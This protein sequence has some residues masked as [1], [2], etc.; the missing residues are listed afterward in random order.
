MFKC[1]KPTVTALT[2]QLVYSFSSK[3]VTIIY[4]FGH[5]TTVL[6]IWFKFI[7]I[8]NTQIF[9]VIL[10]KMLMVHYLWQR[11]VKTVRAN[12]PIQTVRE[13]GYTESKPEIKCQK[14]LNFPHP[15]IYLSNLT[16][17]VVSASGNLNSYME[18]FKTSSCS[19]IYE[20]PHQPMSSENI[21]VGFL[22]Y[23]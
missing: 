9:G 4:L 3:R 5:F 13:D 20:N 22:L 21:L 14:F 17:S 7:Q 11:I 8:N 18:C 15:N 16:L 6:T 1:Q 19:Y 23:V 12:V 10:L 2:L